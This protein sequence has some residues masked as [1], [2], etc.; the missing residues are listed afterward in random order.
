MSVHLATQDE[1][2][3]QNRTLLNIYEAELIGTGRTLPESKT[4]TPY[5]PRVIDQV[6][7]GSR[8][9]LNITGSDSVL[10]K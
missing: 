8:H 7:K 10:E 5:E 9:S 2:L 3:F 4:K 1:S 6:T